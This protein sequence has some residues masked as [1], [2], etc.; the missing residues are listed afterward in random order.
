MVIFTEMSAF[1]ASPYLAKALGCDLYVMNTEFN[2]FFGNNKKKGIYCGDKTEKIKDNEITIIGI[3][4]LR[5]ISKR[6]E[7]GDFKNI[8]LILCDTNSCLEYK[9]WNEFVSKYDIELFIMPDIKDFCFTKYKQL[10]QYIEIDKKLIENKNEKLLITHSPRGKIKYKKKGTDLIIKTINK[11][12]K[13]YDFDFKLI[14]NMS[15]VDSI[16]E[17]S[18]SHIFIDQLIYKNDEIDQNKFGGK[19]EYK[20]GLGKSGIEGMLLNCAVITGGIEPTSNENFKSPP[21]I[22][23]DAKKIYDDLEKLIIDEYHRNN[24]TRNQNFWLDNYM[25]ENYYKKILLK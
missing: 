10:Y 11:L 2:N 23:T 21:I 6:I 3:T 9:W 17:K 8:N 19:I 20:G 13:K 15:M 4:A 12:N 18:K 14:T 22:W 1:F 25:N 16:K 24:V 7:S 5:K